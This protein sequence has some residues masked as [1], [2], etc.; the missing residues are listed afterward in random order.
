MRTNLLSTT[1]LIFA[2]ALL[3]PMGESN[4]Q[5]ALPDI[6][7]GVLGENTPRASTGAGAGK[8]QSLTVPAFESQQQRFLRRPGAETVVSFTRQDNTGAKNNLREY[9]E[10]TPG[11]FFTERGGENSTGIISIRGSDVTQ[12]GPRGGRGVRFFIDG[13]PNGRIATGV[14]QYLLDLKAAEYLEVYRG[15][16][17][18]RYGALAMGGALNLVTKT[19]RSAPGVRFSFSGG[20]YDNTFA[21]VEWGGV[22]DEWDWYIQGNNYADGGYARQAGNHAPRGSFN[23]GWRPTE[24]LETRLNFQ[25]GASWQQLTTSVPLPWLRALRRTGY[26][27]TNIAFPY[28]IRGDFEYE[29]VASKTVYRVD[30][31]TTLEFSPYFVRT[32]FNHVPR[33]SSGVVDN[34]WDDVGANFRLEHKTQLFGLPTEIVAG[35]RPTHEWSHYKRWQSSFGSA[36][37]GNAVLVH[38]N[39]VDSWWLEGHAEAAVEIA[40]RT[41]LF[42]GGQAFWTKHKQTDDYQ[43]PAWPAASSPFGPLGPAAS[44]ARLQN[45]DREY[46]AFNPK[47][48][49][50]W[51]YRDNHFFFAN[52]ARSTE[53]P[54]NGDTTD[55]VGVEND[56]YT[57]GLQPGY[58]S[59]RLKMQRAWT[60][61][62]GLRGAFL[63]DRLQYDVTFYHMLVSNELLSGCVFGLLPGNV[64]QAI[65]SASPFSTAGAYRCGQ[66]NST[67]AFNVGSTRH[68]GVEL[69][70]R[71]KPFVDVFTPG[72]NIFTN[73]TYNF[74]SIHFWNDSSYGWNRMPVIPQHQL[75]AEAGY[76]HPLGFYVS[77][78]VRYVGDRTTT[79][80]GTGGENYRIPDYA[81]IGARLG[82]RDPNDNWNV[83]FEARNIADVAYVGEAQAQIAPNLRTNPYPNVYGG[84]GRAFYAGF[85]YRFDPEK[86]LDNL[87]FASLN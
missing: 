45:Y 2:I 15:A 78:N 30:A 1:S 25:G 66:R 64:Q 40:P 87:P 86:P 49:V 62:I 11:V 26:D 5:E 36:T 27:P 69:G 37:R 52:L 76:R 51:E 23:L 24:D 42:F 55:L 58:L 67:V 21:Q 4:A 63:N 34:R 72:D 39:H 3:T 48:G 84:I 77:G 18:L 10:Q 46:S 59:N 50:N 44:V 43:G 29:R 81:L 35:F 22:K 71:A 73:V 83:W 79:L 28:A 12:T 14:T 74:A 75:Y 13:I 19:G 85:S 65:L 9:L 70:L 82:W 47:I 61:E 41:R 80:D 54:N 17:S 8:S 57:V 56:L 53:P 16:N 20:S 7:I 33:I 31:N 68:D 38:N 6:E 60:G 32:L